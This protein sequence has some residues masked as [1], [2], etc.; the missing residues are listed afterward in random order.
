Y[1]NNAAV[2]PNI[3]Q[4]LI[5][6]WNGTLWL[7]AAPPTLSAS[8]SSDLAGV[9]C[10]SGSECWVVGSIEPAGS[11]RPLIARW[12]GTSWASITAP[13]VPAKPS[14]FL[15]GVTCVSDS[16]CW[17]VGFDFYGVVARSLTMH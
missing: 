6:H 15:N 1:S 12:D 9:A 10:A 17:A 7:L 13:D 5:L 16:D 11:G 4:E 14:N 2:D 3:D 8:D